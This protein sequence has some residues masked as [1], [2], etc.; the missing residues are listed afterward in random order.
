MDNLISVIVPIYNV[1][2]YLRKCI[3]SIMSQTYQNLQILLIDDGSSDQSGNICEEYARL[4]RRIEVVHKKNGG[5]ASARKTGIALARG[6]YVS[7]VDADDYI[8]AELYQRLLEDI[9]VSDADIVHS[10]C[11]IENNGLIRKNNKYKTGIY[12][13]ADSHAE[14]IKTY[15]LKMN[16]NVHMDHNVFSKLFKTDLVKVSDEIVPASQKRGEDLLLVCSCILNSNKVFLDTRAG[17]HYVMRDNSITHCYHMESAIEFGVL[18]DCL[19][20]LFKK[21]NVLDDVRREL[22]IYFKNEYLNL[23]SQVSKCVLI[24]RYEFADIAS[25]RG[26]R[27]VLYGAGKVGQNYYAQMCKYDEIKIV[28]WADRDFK[29]FNY[30]YKEVVGKDTILN[31]DFDLLII[32]LLDETVAGSVKKEFIDMGIAEN[33]IVWKEPLKVLDTEI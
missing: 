24:P 2:R 28:A 33:K 30:N 3:D 23:L 5:P 11:I 4:D 25:I 9:L 20:S 26:K 17:Y 16:S 22:T 18:Y 14:F 10:G 27:I 8:D 6:E 19:I 15:I 1:E 7:F 12:D 21:Y 13:L 31:F 32:A 29:K